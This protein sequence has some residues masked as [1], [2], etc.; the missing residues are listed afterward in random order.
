MPVHSERQNTILRQA[1]KP[2]IIRSFTSGKEG[3]LPFFT[4]INSG[5]LSNCPGTFPLSFSLDIVC[6]VLRYIRIHESGLEYRRSN[7]SDL[8]SCPGF[9]CTKSRDTCGKNEVSA[10]SY[11]TKHLLTRT[12]IS[13]NTFSFTHRI[14]DFRVMVVVLYKTQLQTSRTILERHHMCK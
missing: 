3:V 8:N 2:V 5:I 7:S 10:S 14:T 9:S 12:S 13:L 6:R 11:S 4:G 1:K